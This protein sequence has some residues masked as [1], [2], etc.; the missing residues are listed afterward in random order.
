MG[1]TYV[2]N[3]TTSRFCCFYQCLDVARM[4]GA[5]FYYCDLVLFC[6]AEEC[7]WHAYVI[8]EVALCIEHIIFLRKNSSNQFFGGRLA[9]R[10]CNANHRDIELAAMLTGQVLKSLQTV[11]YQDK[12]VVLLVFRLIDNG[13]AATFFK[14]RSGKLITIKRFAF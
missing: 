4:T 7:L 3:Q 11:V 14:G 10:S 6:Q 13:V 5:H 8:V 2:R 12:T 9:I 1:T